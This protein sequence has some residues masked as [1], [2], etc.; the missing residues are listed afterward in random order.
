LAKERREEINPNA[1]FW[2][3]LMFIDAL[4]QKSQSNNSTTTTT[5][6]EEFNVLQSIVGNDCSIGW[7][8]I[9]DEI[10]FNKR[11]NLISWLNNV[12]NIFVFVKRNYDSTQQYFSECK[13]RE[14]K[15]KYCLHQITQQTIFQC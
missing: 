11:S 1:Y 2:R 15:C 13:R 12:T 6:E 8:Q 7:L 14:G 9:V 4:R 5:I 3:Q 10:P